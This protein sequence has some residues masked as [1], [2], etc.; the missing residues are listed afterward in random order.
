MNRK[1]ERKNSRN[2]FKKKIKKKFS[3]T[4]ELHW[5]TLSVLTVNLISPIV[6]INNQAVTTAVKTKDG[7]RELFSVCFDTRSLTRCYMT[8]FTREVLRGEIR[9]RFT[10]VQGFEQKGVDCNN[11]FI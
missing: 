1:I 3:L 9:T 10:N 8:K 7:T 6:Y 2:E 11:M 4:L 5:H